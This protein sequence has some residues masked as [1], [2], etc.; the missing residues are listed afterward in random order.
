M[1]TP[2]VYTEPMPAC[3]H[4]WDRWTDLP[5]YVMRFYFKCR[6][7]GNIG[8]LPHNGSNLMSTSKRKGI[9]PIQCG[10]EGCK[11]PAIA[12]NKGMASGRL[13]WVCGFHHHGA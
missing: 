5:P 4:V 12:R 3:E 2:M 13:Q 9:K 6:L 11:S 1:G 7:C 10:E 8:W